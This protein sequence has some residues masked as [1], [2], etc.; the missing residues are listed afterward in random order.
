MT[1]LETRI[2]DQVRMTKLAPPPNE[3]SPMM[4]ISVHDH[5]SSFR[6]RHSSLIRH[7]S[8]VI[9]HSSRRGLSISEVLISLAIVSMLL[10][11]VGG[12]FTASASAID[13]NDRFFRASQA[14]RVSMNQVLSVARTSQACQVGS[15]SNPTGDIVTSTMLQVLTA[16]DELRT[17]IHN[18]GD[19]TLRLIIGDDMSHPGHILARH[20]SSASFTGVLERDPATNLRRVVRVVVTVRTQIGDQAL[21]MSGSVAPRRSILR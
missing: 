9:R 8:L 4:T 2:N 10:V 17:Y 3:E 14:G 15:Q 6:F 7:S 16:D 18:A 12:A 11:A 5:A 21:E 13:L 1:K 20:V 19:Q